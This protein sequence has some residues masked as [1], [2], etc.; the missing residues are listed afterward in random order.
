MPFVW[1]RR[2]PSSLLMRFSLLSL[3]VLVCIGGALGW[4]VQ[5]QMEH[6]ALVQQANEVSAVIEG[7]LSRHISARDLTVHPQSKERSRWAQLTQHL[8][9]ADTHLVRVKVWNSAGR[10]VYSNDARQIGHSYPI[11]GDLHTALLGHQ[12]M[13]VSSLTQKENVLD[14]R[15]FTRLLETYIPLR[16]AG[17]VV[18]AYEAYSDLG[19]LDAQLADARRTIWLTVA[20]GFFLLWSTLFAIVQRASRRL[21][22]QMQAISRLEVEAGEAATLRELDRVKDE[23][24]GGASHELRR[25]LASIKGYTASL[26]LPDAHWD[27]KIREEFLRVIDEEADHLSSIVDNL[28]DLARLGSNSLDLMLEPVHLPALTDQIVRRIRSLPTMQPHQFVVEFEEPCPYVQADQT[29]VSQLLLNLLENAVK[30]SPENTT[31][32]VKGWCEDDMVTVSVTD[33]G[34]GL[35]PEQMEH[36]FDKFYRVDSGMTRATEG[37]GLGLAI[38]RGVVEAHG[39]QIRV[40]SRYGHGST[41]TFSLPAATDLKEEGT[42]S[43]VHSSRSTPMTRRSRLA[44]WNN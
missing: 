41:F 29:R 43:A 40:E 13:D 44:P 27:P 26:L 7:V 18:G 8:L 33:E 1:S 32:T 36:V 3:A 15:H 11:D 9:A 21:I 30:Y 25:P 2:M 5:R 38:C 37:T 34:E 10:V 14:R 12:S 6:T 20:A 17:R 31:I 28:F 42:A 24:I 35:T 4:M 23:F 39:G 22:R 19:A 16:A